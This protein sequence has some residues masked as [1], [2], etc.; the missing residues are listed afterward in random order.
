MGRLSRK[1]ILIRYEKNKVDNGEINT[2]REENDQLSKRRRR[3][4]WKR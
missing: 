4:V 2:V 3:Q 1:Y